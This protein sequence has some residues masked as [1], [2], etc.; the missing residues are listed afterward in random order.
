MGRLATTPFF[1]DLEA[2]IAALGGKF[3]AHLHLDRAGTY[4]ETL[5]MLEAQGQRH[6]ATLP[7]WGKHAVIPLVHA[8]DLYR[9]DVLKD[10]TAGYLDLM[11]DLGT[12]RA[13]TVV[14][15]TTDRVGTSAIEAL[16]ALK[17]EFGGRIDFRVGAYSPL[18]FRD[19]EP[20]RWRLVSDAAHVA[21]FVGLLPERDD[22][23]LYPDHIGFEESVRRGIALARDL[24]KP[25][26]IH[27]DQA[28]HAHESGAEAI[29]EIV[30]RSDPSAAD[31]EEPLV[32]LVHLIS[33]SRYDEPRFQALLAKIKALNIGV[34]VCPSAAISMRQ[35]R[36]LTSPTSNSIARVLELLAAGVP[37]RIGSDNICDITSPMGTAD[38]TDEL[39]VLAN[40]VRFYDIGI[41]AK[42]GAGRLLTDDERARIQEHLALDHRFVVEVAGRWLQPDR[43]AP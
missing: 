39:F 18:G 8:S 35:Y 29:V 30:R 11:A 5:A 38:L 2:L 12:S 42:L 19:D 33:P 7:L 23:S 27:V 1:R 34:I 20:Q 37:V 36:V 15:C 10:R 31:R 32:W 28:N 41:L 26:H 17:A 6:G 21:D 9:P 13:D 22:R 4:R 24:D 14:D 40:A 25:I 43:A 16:L 3:N